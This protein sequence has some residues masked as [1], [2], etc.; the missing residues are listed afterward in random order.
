MDNTLIEQLFKYPWCKCCGIS[1]PNIDF[2]C[3]KGCH[4][5]PYLLDVSQYYDILTEPVWLTEHSDEKSKIDTP[6]PA[7]EELTTEDNVSVFGSS[8][9]PPPRDPRDRRHYRN[10]QAPKSTQILSQSSPNINDHIGFSLDVWINVNDPIL[11][12]MNVEHS[13]RMI[14]KNN[15][16]G[17][18]LNCKCIPKCKLILNDNNTVVVQAYDIVRYKNKKL[19]SNNPCCECE[20][21][22]MDVEAHSCYKAN[23]K[24]IIYLNTIH[25]ET[26]ADLLDIIDKIGDSTYKSICEYRKKV[27]LSGILID[28]DDIVKIEECPYTKKKLIFGNHFTKNILDK[29]LDVKCKNLHS[30]KF[31]LEIFIAHMKSKKYGDN[32]KTKYSGFNIPYGLRGRTPSPLKTN[33][34]EHLPKIINREIEEETLALFSEQYSKLSKE[35]TELC[36]KIENIKNAGVLGIDYEYTYI[37]VKRNTHHC[38]TYYGNYDDKLDEKFTD[39]D[40]YVPTKYTC[41]ESFT[42]RDSD[43]TYLV[44]RNHKSENS[45]TYPKIILQNFLDNVIVFDRVDEK[46]S[47][48]KQLYPPEHNGYKTFFPE[49]PKMSWL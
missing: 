20:Y 42:Y 26:V 46:I 15:R 16:R 48:R 12:D 29:E 49:S 30:D 33:I 13:I 14:C 7:T 4:T 36:E 6:E 8:F 3:P 10:V 35:Y 17:N 21:G 31:F 28:R 37:N 43:Q 41:S 19:L 1:V 18:Y 2:L 40:R 45:E 23:I 25:K 27:Y 39:E 44:S 47:L 9:K 22:I 38:Y 34:M 24:R 5:Y 32:Y 11:T